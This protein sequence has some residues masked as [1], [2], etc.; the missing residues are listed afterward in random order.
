MMFNA[1]LTVFR[2]SA[3]RCIVDELK[4]NQTVRV[5]ERAP[6]KLLVMIGNPVNQ[7]I[8]AAPLVSNP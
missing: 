7:A 3:S 2:V 8:N 1:I 4:V 6:F 5:K